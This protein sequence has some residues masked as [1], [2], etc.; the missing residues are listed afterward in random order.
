MKS[1]VIILLLAICMTFG[2]FA[3]GQGDSGIDTGPVTIEMMYQRNEFSEAQ[4]EA[5]EAANPNITVEFFENNEQRLQAAIASGNPPHVIRGTSLDIPYFANR[6]LLVALD[7]YILKSSLIDRGD[8]E[9]VVDSYR[10]NVDTKK[11]GTGPLWGLPKDYSLFG[12][13]LFR[14]DVFEEV[15]VP[16]P[17]SEGYMN[18]NEFYEI[19]KALVAREGDTTLR[20]G[21]SGFINGAAETFLQL[22]LA[23]SDA[24]PLY[25]ED[26]K[27]VD[28][29]G[30]PEAV[31]II[32]WMLK[33][34][35]E[36]IIFSVIDPAPS[37]GGAMLSQ[38]DGDPRVATYQFGYWAG[39][40]FPPELKDGEAGYMITPYWGDKRV[41]G[42]S[43]TGIMQMERGSDYEKESAWKLMEYYTAGEPAIGRA[44]SGWGLPMLKSMRDLIP[45]DAEYDRL[46]KDVTLNQLNRGEYVIINGNPY[47]RNPVN[48]A[49][50]R[51]LQ[52]F[53]TG[54][55]ATEDEFIRQVETMANDLIAEG[56]SSM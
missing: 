18:Y 13:V 52:E 37:W 45:A 40:M 25:S 28:I 7:N 21:F 30:N 16:I 39:A 32:K 31:K 41:N 29:Y 35:K 50:N 42:G 3:G 19:L 46:R 27:K 34:Y 9:S 8:L 17:D 15:G 38:A 24:E 53:L 33:V 2:L 22:C 54:A 49:W 4:Q 56:V 10:F 47:A 14:K 1:L 43:I 12:D 20:W 44:S 6:E 23:Q 48:T 11:S 36:R 55:I 5:F 51:Y 26:M